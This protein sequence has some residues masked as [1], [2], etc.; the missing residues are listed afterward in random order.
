MP[1]VYKGDFP[2]DEH[3]LF[4]PKY[5]IPKPPTPPAFKKPPSGEHRFSKEELEHAAT[6][7]KRVKN[8]CPH[9]PGRYGLRE[10]RG[11][12]DC[13]RRIA[14]DIRERRRKA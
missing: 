11:Y 3:D 6:W 4:G 1:P 5:P 8:G 12:D 2:I 10:C 7:R 14:L 9:P 13:V